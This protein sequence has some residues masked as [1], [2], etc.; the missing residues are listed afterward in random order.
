MAEGNGWKLGYDRNP[1]SSS[2][3][4]A[5]IGSDAFSFAITRQEYNDFIKVNAPIAR[6]FHLLRCKPMPLPCKHSEARATRTFIPSY[7]FWW[8]K[9]IHAL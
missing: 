3:Y 5:L 1:D 7:K 4:S 8:P 6:P 9:P 2:N